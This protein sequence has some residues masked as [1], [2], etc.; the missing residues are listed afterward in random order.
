MK[1]TRFTF[2]ILLALAATAAQAQERPDPAED[3]ARSRQRITVEKEYYQPWSNGR[4]LVSEEGRYLKHANGKPFFWLGDTGWLLPEKLTREDAVY[5]LD[6]CAEAGFNVVQVQTINGVPAYNVYGESS[7]PN[8]YDFSQVDAAGRNGYWGHMDYIIR[9][10]EKRGI[11]IGMVCIWGGLVKNGLMDVKQA[12]SYGRFLAERYKDAPNI[13]WFIGGDIRGDIQRPVWETLAR[14]IKSIDKQHLM[15]FHPFGRSTSALWYNDAEWL[16]FNMFQSG[17]RRYG[18]KKTPDEVYP[19]VG[20]YQEEDNWR[21]VEKSLSCRPLKPCIDGEP[22]YE[23]IPEGLHDGSKGFWNDNDVRRYAYW[24]V[25]A[26]SFG[27]TYGHNAIMQFRRPGDG[28]AYDAYQYWFEGVEDPGFRQM[29]H[30]KNLMLSLP[31]FERVPDQSVLIDNLG[32]RYDRTVATRGKDYILAY[33]YTAAPI[34]VDFTK[35]SG[36][37]KKVWWYLPKSGRLAFAGTF[38]NGVHTLRY[39]ISYGS[40]NDCVLV[41]VDAD[42]HYFSEEQTAIE[43][44]HTAPENR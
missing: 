4:L 40:G 11:Y 29:K 43:D 30:L 25:F 34:T 31:F 16:D 6:K 38:D 1:K 41:I 3:D 35:I 19:V 10:A 28:A 22:S 15:T 26:G 44:L 36:A 20:S 32:V 18:Q 7:H 42:K 14:T 21:Y 9:E 8:G 5:Y 33:S 2:M 27:H 13:I 12:K 17:H 23:N 24:S 37:R 39:D